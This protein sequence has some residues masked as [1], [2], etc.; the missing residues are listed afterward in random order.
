M[1]VEFSPRVTPPGV[2][3]RASGGG[4]DAYGHVTPPSD[5]WRFQVSENSQGQIKKGPSAAMSPNRPLS[6]NISTISH[7]LFTTFR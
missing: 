4:I 3:V 2:R 5:A 1:A 6:T 7:Y